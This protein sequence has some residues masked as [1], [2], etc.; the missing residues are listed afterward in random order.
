[1]KQFAVLDIG[2]LSI[3]MRSSCFSSG[4][5]MK[6]LKFLKEVKHE[7][8]LVSWPTP[9]EVAISS[10][11]VAILVGISGLVFFLSDTASY[12]LINLFLGLKGL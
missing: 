2:A 3:I 11:F 12:W 7:A 8:E 1:M 10:V 6:W 9:R 4:I 5:L